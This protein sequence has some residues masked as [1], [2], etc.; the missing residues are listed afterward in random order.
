MRLVG[1]G[2]WEWDGEPVGMLCSVSGLVRGFDVHENG[3]CCVACGK[4][5]IGPGMETERVGRLPGMMTWLSDGVDCVDRKMVAR[6]CL[7]FPPMV[8]IADGGPQGVGGL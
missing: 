2:C 5:F 1:A 4:F 8:E 6:Y 3:A 7:S